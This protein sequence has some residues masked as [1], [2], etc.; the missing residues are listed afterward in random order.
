MIQKMQKKNI[1]VIFYTVLTIIVG[2]FVFITAPNL[3]PLYSDG[4]FFWLMIITIYSALPLLSGFKPEQYTDANGKPAFRF[5]K[6]DVKTSKNKKRFIIVLGGLW[7]IFI[8]V[9]LICGPLFFSKIYRDQMQ[10]PTVKE[11]TSNITT[12]DL[13]QIPI[14]DAELALNLADKKLGEEPSLGSQV[15]LGEP[16]MQNVDGKLVWVVPLHHSGFFKW[17]ANM[18]GAA[19]YIKVSATDLKDVVYVDNYKI[20]IQPNSYFMHDLSRKVRFGQGL[21]SGITDYSFEINDEG[22]PYWAVTTYTNKCGFALPEANGIILV[23]AE[24]GKQEKYNMKSIPKWVDRVQPEKFLVNQFNNKGKY[25]HGVFNFSNKD[26]FKTTEGENIVY[27]N[28][29]CYLFT[30]VTSVGIDNSA[31]GFVMIDMV[32]KEPILYRMSGA[33]E[34]AAKQTAQGKVQ[35]KGY[36]ATAPII[37]NVFENPTYF[38][39]LKDNA[40]LVK[41]FAFVSIKNY[42]IVGV[43]DTI[44]EAKADYAKALNDSNEHANLTEKPESTEMSLYGAVDRINFTIKDNKTIYTFTIVEKPGVIFNVSL[45]ANEMLPLTQKGDSVQIKYTTTDTTSMQVKEFKNITVAK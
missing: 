1:P 29:N 13:N 7:V 27:N 31:T 40:K 25:V 41:K 39:T 17:A 8:V 32:T 12:V 15:V 21:F 3:N 18:D 22:K 4:A 24:S 36:L 44:T 5:A 42:N 28:G 34:N 45:E 38:M 14:V 20:K 37:L 9:N 19:G 10:E 11:F 16:T 23:D 43:G 33:T 6:K 30:G 35:E 2:L 26:K